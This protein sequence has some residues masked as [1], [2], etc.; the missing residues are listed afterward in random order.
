MQCLQAAADRF[1]WGKEKPS[2][3]HGFGLACGVL[4][5][6]Y[7]A[8]CAELSIV[9]AAFQGA[10]VEPAP[11]NVRIDRVLAAFECGAIMNP[12]HLKGQIEGSVMLGI[13]GA[14]FEAVQFDNGRILNPHLATYRVPRFSDLPIIETVLLNRKDLPSA[15]AGGTPIVALAPAIGNAIFQATGSRIRSLP[16]AP[17]GFVKS[18]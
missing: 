9:P 18:L 14:L 4:N 2:A 7:V 12:E 1:G 17:K 13:G 10:E 3:D 5:D 8:M 11:P 15:G 16:M 6:S